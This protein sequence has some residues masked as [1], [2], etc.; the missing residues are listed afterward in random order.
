MSDKIKGLESEFENV[1]QEKEKEKKKNEKLESEK[2]NWRSKIDHLEDDL[3][4]ALKVADTKVIKNILCI[5][6]II[7]NQVYFV[8]FF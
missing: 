5:I 1:M 6:S 4:H 3:K 2:S 7:L 8:V